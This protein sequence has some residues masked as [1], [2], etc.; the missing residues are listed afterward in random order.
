VTQASLRV[1]GGTSTRA[2]ATGSNAGLARSADLGRIAVQRADESVAIFSRRG[3]LLQEVR[4]SSVSEVVLR[5][6]YLVI[7]TRAQ[8]LEIFDAA[9]GEHLFTRRVPPGAGRLDVHSRLAVYAVERRVHAMNLRT[10]RSAVIATAPRDLVGLALEAPG[11]VYAFDSP[12]ARGSETGNVVFRPFR[13][14]RAAV[15]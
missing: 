12:Y 11:A 4:V 1:I 6:D 14:M 7:L 9:S 15:S 2:I 13:L 3:G 5:K 8:T 10:G